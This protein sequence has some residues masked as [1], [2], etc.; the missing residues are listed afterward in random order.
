MFL[1]GPS[2]HSESFLLSTFELNT[3]TH[4]LESE[5]KTDL[6]LLYTN[7][8]EF[9]KQKKKENFYAQLNSLSSS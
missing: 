6:F 4:T 8:Q 9:K 3:D 5:S 7:D 1:L 2:I